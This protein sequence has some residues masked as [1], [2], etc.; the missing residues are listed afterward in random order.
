MIDF[1]SE[2]LLITGSN[3]ML[4][5]ALCR[6]LDDYF[7]A[8]QKTFG[9]DFPNDLRDQG[10]VENIF[11][12]IKPTYVIHTAA[13][14]GGVQANTQ[15]LADFY[16]DNIRINTNVLD[17]CHKYKVKKALS[18][19]STCVYPDKVIYPLTEDQV[20]NGEPHESNYAYAYSKRML[21]IQ[22]RAYRDQFGD[23]FITIIPNN[24]FGTYDNFDLNNSHVIP[25]MIRKIYEAKKYN[26]SNVE[27]WGNGHQLREFTFVDDLAQI[28]LLLLENYNEK[29][30][31]NV[32]STLE[33]EISYLAKKISEI[34]GYE[35][36]ICWNS[37]KPSGQFRKPSSNLKF[38]NFI[39]KNNLNFDYTPLDIG[40]KKVCEWFTCSYPN[41][42]GF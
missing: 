22:S 37:K 14:V 33:Y 28:I 26:F 20:H 9:I 30:P 6:V 40:L 34:L 21:D 25:A 24:L 3:G 16:L 35:G 38:K 5:Y 19:L 27:M 23:N 13:H 8:T 15:F 29:E 18:L 10:V 2:V 39:A 7:Y 36:E 42:R 17:C 4:G 11:E 31:L 41:I 12:K 1:N 32:G